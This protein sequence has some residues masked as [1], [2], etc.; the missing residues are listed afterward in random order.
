LG[1]VEPGRHSNTRLMINQVIAGI[2]CLNLTEV[3]L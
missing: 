1:M 2:N 3:K